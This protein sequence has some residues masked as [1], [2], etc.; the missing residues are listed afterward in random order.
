MN[1]QELR[2]FEPKVV[3]IGTHP[4]IIQSML[5]YDFLIGHTTPS[6][7]A[8]IANGRQ[9]VR[10]FFGKREIL[11]PVYPTLSS[12]PKELKEKVNMI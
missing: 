12:V 7:A 3:S 5:D 2:E 9:Y 6:V 4:G 11:I 1:I 10:F 8:I